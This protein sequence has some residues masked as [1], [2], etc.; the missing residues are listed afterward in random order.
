MSILCFILD[1]YY[2]RVSC[3]RMNVQLLRSRRRKVLSWE[4]RRFPTSLV[5]NNDPDIL[6]GGPF[7]KTDFIGEDKNHPFLRRPRLPR[8]LGIK[9][10]IFIFQIFY[11]CAFILKW[12]PHRHLTK[13]HS[14]NGSE[15]I[16]INNILITIYT[17]DKMTIKLRW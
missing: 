2:W 7:S 13:M 14:R 6:L 11:L 16:A 8:P 12:K 17:R 9:W 1:G 3:I 10:I 15:Y 5:N 4:V